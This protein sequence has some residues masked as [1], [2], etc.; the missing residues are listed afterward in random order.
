[1]GLLR[2]SACTALGH[3]CCV[4]ACV[5]FTVPGQA[6]VKRQTA[7]QQPAEDSCLRES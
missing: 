6:H 4:S 7:E 5:C 3:V 1:M 2:L